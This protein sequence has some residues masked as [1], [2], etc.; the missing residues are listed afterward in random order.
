MTLGLD[1]LSLQD[2]PDIS[3]EP[4]AKAIMSGRAPTV[5]DVKKSV[6]VTALTYIQFLALIYAS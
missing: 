6:K 5:L 4:I 3:T 1:A 2:T